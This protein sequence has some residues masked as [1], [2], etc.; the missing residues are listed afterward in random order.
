MLRHG[1]AA[2]NFSH[3]GDFSAVDPWKSLRRCNVADDGSILAYYGDNDYD[4]TGGN[5]QVCNYLKKFYSA[6]SADESNNIT[7]SI[8]DSPDDVDVNEVAVAVNPAF[9]YG[10]TNTPSDPKTVDYILVGAF[11]ASASLTYPTMLESKASTLVA[12]VR[13]FNSSA[14]NL[15]I[16]ARARNPALG[17]PFNFLTRNQANGSEDGTVAPD[18]QASNGAIVESSTL[19]AAGWPIEGSRSLKVT[20]PATFGSSGPACLIRGAT[21]VVL[22]GPNLTYTFSF[23]AYAPDND[24]MNYWMAFV[25]GDPTL[26][27]LNFYETLVSLSSTPTRYA[28]TTPFVSSGTTAYLMVGTWDK[29]A[30]AAVYFDELQFEQFPAGYT[31]PSSLPPGYTNI[32]P[33]GAPSA[34]ALPPSRPA[35]GW[36]MLT[37]RA[38]A[39]TQLLWTVENANFL[40]WQVPGMNSGLI[41]TAL[42]S[43]PAP[44]LPAYNGYTGSYGVQMGNLSGCYFPPSGTFAEMY[45]DSALPTPENRGTPCVPCYRGFELPWGNLQLAVEG[46]ATDVSDGNMRLLIADDLYDWSFANYADAGIDLGTLA[47]LQSHGQIDDFVVGTATVGG[48]K[49]NWFFLARNPTESGGVRQQMY[50]PYST[51]NTYPSPVYVGG[52]FLWAHHMFS[53]TLGYGMSNEFGTRIQFTPEGV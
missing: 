32:D 41:A 48:V 16:C 53:Y 18:F 11:P 14:V 45:G 29:T 26:G 9:I 50:I 12:P 22:P 3:P 7:Y 39:A 30:N 52:H 43:N 44:T 15:A 42:S 47:D 1:D 36:G 20:N 6:V 21:D 33:G 40:P 27:F 28:F 4:D 38:H 23:W 2:A 51:E 8:S 19:T 17:V 13:P 31:Y 46:V 34:W 5:G 10:S 25:E 24:G 35:K 49:Q 37:Y